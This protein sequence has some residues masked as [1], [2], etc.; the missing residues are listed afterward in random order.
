[1][2]SIERVDEMVRKNIAK[3]TCTYILIQSKNNKN[4]IKNRYKNMR[5]NVRKMH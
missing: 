1:M 5:N 4:Y 3:Y 2:D